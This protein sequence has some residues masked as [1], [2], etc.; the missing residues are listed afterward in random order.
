[1]KVFTPA[2]ILACLLATWSAVSPAQVTINELSATSSEYLLK[3]DAQGHSSPGAGASWRSAAFSRAGAWATGPAP[4]GWGHGNVATDVS[5]AMVNQT[6]SI[7]LRKTFTVTAAQAASSADLLLDV[8]YDDGFIAWVNGVEVGRANMGPPDQHVYHDQVAFRG[9]STTDNLDLGPASG[10]LVA[11]T[12]VISIQAAN[13][14]LSGNMRISGEMEISGGATLVPAGSTWSYFPGHVEPSG[15]LFESSFLPGGPLRAEWATPGFDDSSWSSGAGP[16][17]LDV[18]TDYALGTNLLS[19][20]HNVTPSVYMRQG[21][22]VTAAQISSAPSLT[23]TA[24]YDDGFVAFLNGVEIAR[25]NMGSAG[26][27]Y[28]HNA[29]ADSGHNASGDSGSATNAP[30][31]YVI[32]TA[33]LV[34]GQNVLG[35]QSHNQSLNSSDLILDMELEITGGSVLAPAAGNF[36]YLVGLSE[37]TP[38]VS[39]PESKFVDWFELKNAG[40]TA[41]DLSGWSVTDEPLLPAKFVLPAGT[42]IPA[43]GYLVILADGLEEF[44][45]STS[46]LHASFN[47]SGSGEYL[48]LYDASGSVVSE[49]AP[50]YPSQRIFQSYGIP[51]GGGAAVYFDEPTPGAA[52]GSGATY[53]DRVDAPDFSVPGGHHSGTVTVAMSSLTPGADIIYTT[54]GSDPTLTNGTLYSSPLTLTQ[55]SDKGGHVVR[56]R[57]FKTGSVESRIK[58]HTYLIDQNPLLTGAPALIMTGEAGEVFYA[59]NGVLTISGGTYVSNRWQ[60]VTSTDY[61][62]P[63]HRGRA[64]ER[65]GFLEY[66]EPDGDTFRE[67]MGV[68]IAASSWSRPRMRLRNNYASPFPSSSTQK[69][70]FNIWFR[71]DYGEPEVNFPIMGE[72]YPVKTFSQ[73]RQ[74]AGKNDIRNPFYHDELLRRLYSDMGQESAVGVIN[75]LYINGVF[76]GYYNTCE[77]LREPFMQAHHQSEEE[78]DIR[79][80]N[81]YAEGDDLAWQEMMLRASADLSIQANWDA[82]LEYVDPVNAAD[83]FLVNAYGATWD[84][85]H[86]NWVGARERTTNGRY[87]FYVWDAEGAFGRGKN[88]NHNTIS[89]DLLGGSQALPRLFQALHASE[90]FRL[91]FA[92]RVHK[93]LFNGGALDDRD[94]AS[95]NIRERKDVLVAALQPLLTCVHNQTVNESYYDNWVNPST[96]RRGYLL[97]PT[98]THFA[99]NDLWP[100]TAAPDFSRMGGD[101]PSGFQLSMSQNDPGVI[102]YT[103]DGSDPRGFGGSVASSAIA[104]GSPVTL[105]GLVVPAR[106]RILNSNGEW[107]PMTEADFAVGVGP[108]TTANLAVVKVHFEPAQ[109]SAA[110]IAA[111][112]LDGTEFE[113]LL[114]ENIGTNPVDLT[115]V[116][117]SSGVTFDFAGG[118][119]SALSPGQQVLVVENVDAFQLRYGTAF[120]AVIAGKWSGKLSN[121]GERLLLE[122]SAG[123]PIQDFSYDD[124]PPWPVLPGGAD[125]ALEII[126]P[127]GNHNDPL[128]WQ[129]AT[130][131]Q[132]I[133]VEQ[134]AGTNLVA[135]GSSRFLGKG[136]VGATTGSQVFTIRNL[137]DLDLAG[138][139][140]ISYGGNAADFSVGSLGTT[141]LAGG[142]VTTV[143]VTFT[144][145]GVGGRG[146]TLRIG[147]NDMDENPFDIGL[148]GTGVPV[149]DHGGD[150]STA[151]DMT[152]WI[153]TGVAGAPVPSAGKHGY[154]ELPGDEDWFQF[155]V[156]SPALATIETTGTTDTIGHL[157]FASGAELASDDNSGTGAGNFKI[158]EELFPGTYAVRVRGGNPSSTTGVY[159]LHVN[160]DEG[161][162][163]GSGQ[164]R[165]DF[166][167]DGYPDILWR[168]DTGETA[169]HFYREE[170]FLRGRWTT[171]Q[172][173]PVATVA[174]IGD[175]DGDGQADM[176]WESSGGTSIHFMDGEVYLAPGQWTSLQ[177]A[178]PWKPVGVGDFNGD[179]KADILY[180][181]PVNR[182]MAIHYMQAQTVASQ[183][184]TY[185]VS[186]NIEGVAD[187]NGDGMADL[188]LRSPTTLVAAYHYLNNG[189]FAGAAAPS[190]QV[191]STAWDLMGADD[192]DGNGSSDLLWRNNV[193]GR[194][195]IHYYDGVTYNRGRWISS[196]V[197]NLS[198]FP[199]LK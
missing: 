122:D 17:G 110:E 106:A 132:E 172:V 129:G 117:F 81:E 34:P 133:Q 51:A 32:P 189:D 120:N 174:G 112:V 146:T 35:A 1:M 37:P 31:T 25:G 136:S 85:P 56:A 75:T 145:G 124:G 36:N 164:S 127:A 18:N 87:R 70:S 157:H 74:R 11:G 137:G 30:V 154:I 158:V 59:P 134:P 50:E 180:Q 71:S 186:W 42:T 123:T 196:Q 107:S 105:S 104:Y 21:F 185:A 169:I 149:D 77:R 116:R 135:G 78:W 4:F 192:F 61:N 54:D 33:L 113:F 151:S 29:T 43:G 15:G 90:E 176:L 103:L 131:S 101:V 195:V 153:T 27:L 163:S 62:L 130:V 119:V 190:Q 125:F 60:A 94:L 46:Y 38:P 83:Y 58:T 184:S 97:G 53:A 152:P 121:N 45:G 57:A 118:A 171:Q 89:S 82:L 150:Q 24:D 148:T 44:N 108:A 181:N 173:T 79:Q 161:G 139:T 142:Q 6:P 102:Y 188:L 39:S 114:L 198:W 143:T 141:S 175:F 19:Q 111:G 52:N 147:S 13:Q 182:M 88:I 115:D 7:Y 138:L 2:K 41:V 92:D 93:H 95:S 48:G 80:V 109:P 100:A 179:G 12:N 47:L 73:L 3:R 10:V 99:S 96:G 168:R 126:D 69:P 5:A 67:D 193:D 84:W 191:K 170:N 91:I 55:V 199:I 14:T 98:A 72:D 28:A 178:A 40:A 156:T 162:Y 140:A 166:D 9:A 23:L 165:K 177:V 160:L 16:I 66:F 86:N 144:P 159:R 22:T 167:G 197:T 63:I 26:Q 8:Q 20:M 49:Y 76:K 64:Y 65:A 194:S 155:T 183:K 187:F 68:R 128:N